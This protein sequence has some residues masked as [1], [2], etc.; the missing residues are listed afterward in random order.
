MKFELI[1]WVLLHAMREAG[2]KNQYTRHELGI[3]T[4]PYW[5][6]PAK[7]SSAIITSDKNLQK[8]GGKL[9]ETASRIDF[10][11]ACY[12]QG[13][14]QD[15]FVFNPTNWTEVKGAQGYV[16]TLSPSLIHF[17]RKEFKGFQNAVKEVTPKDLFFTTQLS[18]LMETGKT[19]FGFIDTSIPTAMI[20]AICKP[21]NSAFIDQFLA[22]YISVT[23]VITPTL[24]TSLV[25]AES[26]SNG[27]NGYGGGAKAEAETDKIK[28]RNEAVKAM[29]ATL[30]GDYSLENYHKALGEQS[31]LIAIS[32]ELGL[33]L[34]SNLSVSF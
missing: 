24:F 9:M 5:A 32:L 8:L 30:Y 21:E 3:K 27:G 12:Y 23:E 33:A 19:Y 18:R 7:E 2:I 17:V 29:V 34:P 11:E 22:P 10:N 28:A 15:C 14:D 6:N 31:F 25:I 20:E 4:M 13:T 1:N 16:P 26:R